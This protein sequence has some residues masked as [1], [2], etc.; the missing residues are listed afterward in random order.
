MFTSSAPPSLE[1]ENWPEAIDRNE[2]NSHVKYM[3]LYPHD[4]HMVPNSYT[5]DC[6]GFWKDRLTDP[7]WL[8]TTM[9]KSLLDQF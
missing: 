3:R 8:Q 4:Y 2:E 1:N 7:N 5:R 9:P 6:E